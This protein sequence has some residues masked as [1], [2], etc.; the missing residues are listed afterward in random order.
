MVLFSD[1]RRKRCA[2]EQV[3]ELFPF[4]DRNRPRSHPREGGDSLRY[5]RPRRMYLCEAWTTRSR[6]H[7]FRHDRFRHDAISS[8]QVADESGDVSAGIARKSP[9][10][11]LF[12]GCGSQIAPKIRQTHRLRT[13]ANNAKVGGLAHR[14]RRTC[15]QRFLSAN[16]GRLKTPPAPCHRASSSRHDGFPGRPGTAS[17]RLGLAVFVLEETRSSVRAPISAF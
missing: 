9:P 14:E 10:R 12:R 15:L 4:G 8:R 2:E 13:K 16:D 6:G 11:R 5:L 17:N 7:R 1:R 3:H